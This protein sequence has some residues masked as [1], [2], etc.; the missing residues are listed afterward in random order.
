MQI[1]LHEHKIKFSFTQDVLYA[2]SLAVKD[3]A[4][5]LEVDLSYHYNAFSAKAS[6]ADIAQLRDLQRLYYLLDRKVESAFRAGRLRISFRLEI[7]YVFL[8]HRQIVYSFNN[9]NLQLAIDQIDQQIK[10]YRF[11]D[12]LQLRK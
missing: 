4:D 5:T 3:R 2:L 6:Y 10:S 8:L 9:H 7:S 1:L 12:Q 11:A